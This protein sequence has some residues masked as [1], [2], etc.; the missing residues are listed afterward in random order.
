MSKGEVEY[1][2]ILV[3]ACRDRGREL[4]MRHSL[5]TYFRSIGACGR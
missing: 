3:L 1:L 5:S 4:I 2:E